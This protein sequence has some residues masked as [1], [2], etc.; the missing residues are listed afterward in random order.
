[1]ANA[2][3]FDVELDTMDDEQ[4][5]EEIQKIGK[6]LTTECL[7]KLAGIIDARKLFDIKRLD[8]LID[9]IRSGIDKFC[10]EDSEDDDDSIL[11]AKFDSK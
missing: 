5:A 10:D 3:V 1:M 7:N 2:L 4:Q 6:H 8:N 11:R 9:V